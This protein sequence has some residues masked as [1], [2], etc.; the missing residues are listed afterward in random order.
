MSMVVFVGPTVPVELCGAVLDATYLPPASQG[1][2]YRA[3]LDHP[4]AIGIIDGFFERV[5][6]VWH[7]E[8]L[9]AM[10]QGIHVFGA[11]SMGALRA[12]E[13]APFGMVGVGAIFESF[14]DGRLEGDD[15]VTIIHGEA[16]AGYPAASVAMVDIRATLAAAESAGII[17][18]DTRVALVA[19]GKALF[20]PDRSYPRLIERARAAGLPDAE[21]DALESWLPAGGVSQKR[22]DALAML[23]L[24]ATWQATPH[25][26][27]SVD[28]H[29]EHT[30]VWEQVV[31]RSGRQL[32]AARQDDLPHQWLVEE[33]Q[34]DRD[35][36][37]RAV[38]GALTR[39]LALAES[40]R[41][42]VQVGA[43]L[44]NETVTA[45]RRRHALVDA[46]AL[47][48]WITG[49]ELDLD[50]FGL[51]VQE[52]ARIGW[53]RTMYSPDTARHLAR[54]LQSSGWY[55]ALAA[56]AR[57]KQRVL[58]AHGLETPSLAVTGV[59][60][61]DVLRWFFETQRGTAVPA[62][63]DLH[64]HAVGCPNRAAFVQ[65]VL[66]EYPLRQAGDLDRSG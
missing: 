23:R 41:Q 32:A 19:A 13:L 11:A 5:P 3:A 51:L 44:V 28:F 18:A 56:R 59:E 15:E 2:V 62:R 45:L 37:E 66:R 9:W 16:A 48:A 4:S 54:W 64:A 57:D 30:D 53:V 20:Y 40:E 65:A 55:G 50:D 43:P 31:N 36:Y 47:P 60:E 22:D 38:G 42:G 26:P 1:D 17:G 7:K 46:D 63:L 35:A 12:A 25:P 24:M 34:L 33:L 61:A 21:I 39:A 49:Q 10:A 58:A 14:R 52:E 8:I 29:F 27:L 6:A